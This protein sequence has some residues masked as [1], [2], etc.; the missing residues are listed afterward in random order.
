M[1]L[2]VSYVQDAKGFNSR[3]SSIEKMKHNDCRMD[4]GDNTALLQ[5][6]GRIM[7]KEVTSMI[8]SG[9]NRNF[10]SHST[11]QRLGLKHTRRSEPDTV[12]LADNHGLLTTHYI[13]VRIRFG[14]GL[15]R[16][17]VA[18]F[19]LLDTKVDAILGIN[20]IRHSNPKPQID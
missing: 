1:E 20:W 16:H 18:M 13:I 8:Y 7:N 6:Q 17:H 9:A 4:R 14:I 15:V 11:A 10:M 2:D 3:Q 12:P 5:I 19:D